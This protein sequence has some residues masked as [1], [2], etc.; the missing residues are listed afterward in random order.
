[1][2][3]SPPNRIITVVD[4]ATAPDWL[5][6]SQACELS[7]YDRGF[8]LQVVE[9]DGVDLNDK[10]RI[11]KRSLFEWLELTAELSTGLTNHF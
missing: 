2:L 5:T 10:G 4:W 3:V 8:M 11:E 9:A 6:V 7:G 1:M